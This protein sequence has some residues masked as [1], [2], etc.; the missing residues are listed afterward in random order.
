MTGP[1]EV[2]L[3][4]GPLIIS[5][6]QR[7]GTL[8]GAGAAEVRRLYRLRRTGRSVDQ[9]DRWAVRLGFHP[10]ELWPD[11]STFEA[12]LAEAS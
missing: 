9:A 10:A 2:R 11:W 8:R 1:P 3:P 4:A 5:V 7:C 12:G 6:S